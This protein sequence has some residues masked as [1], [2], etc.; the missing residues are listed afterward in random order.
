MVIYMYYEVL[1]RG[2]SR[3]VSVG[4]VVVAAL[5]AV[6]M[7]VWSP[8]GGE[9]GVGHATRSTELAVA[10]PGLDSGSAVL[11][12]RFAPAGGTTSGSGTYSVT[13]LFNNSPSTPTSRGAGLPAGLATPGGH[14]NIC[15][16][17]GSYTTC[18]TY[19]GQVSS[20]LVCC[21]VTYTWW[22]SG[23]GDYSVSCVAYSQAIAAT[24]TGHTGYSDSNITTT[25]T[26]SSVTFSGPNGTYW[27]LV[28]GQSGELVSGMAPDGN[29]TVAGANVSETVNFVPGKTV[30]LHYSEKGLIPGTAWCTGLL[31][32]C[33]TTSTLSWGNSE[34]T[35]GTYPLWVAPVTGYTASIVSP[36]GFQ[37]DGY[38]TLGR[39][40]TTV[41][42][43][44]SPV[45][46]PVTIN[47]TGLAAGVAWSLKLTC[48]DSPHNTSGCDGM[49]GSGKDVATSTG[50]AIDV[51]LR[52]G[53]YSWSVKPV[54]GYELEV[55]G[56]V[57]TMWSGTI[58]VAAR[59]ANSLN[60]FFQK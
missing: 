57:D 15:I 22:D 45:D 37:N 27:Y 25:T 43:K 39:A 49:K 28:H 24:G 16:G 13:F 34:L 1:P 60:I 6:A 21:T 53:T 59:G 7:G 44:F 52:A 35:P 38:I 40:V 12:H 50:G 32:Y 48:T 36:P 46:Y 26:N 20:W 23:F 14:G 33:S 2:M 8:V 3:P 41:A 42:V 31:G 11:V 47:E 18:S 30:G 55:D 51:Q 58:T 54:K 10:G 5:A 56:T 9:I 29:I 17:C 4:L 19:T